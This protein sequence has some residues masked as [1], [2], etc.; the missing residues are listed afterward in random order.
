[1]SEMLQL[2]PRVGKHTIELSC[3]E[4]T[5]LNAILDLLI[6]S[7]K[8]FPPPSSL[9]IIDVFLHQ[10]RPTAEYRATL[11]LNEHRLRK[12]LKDLNVSAGGN[13]CTINREKQQKLLRNL[14]HQQPALF[15][16]LWTLVTHSYYKLLA[17]CS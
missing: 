10:L 11:M 8:D 2:S 7:D 5:Q 15:Q 14:E 9:Q 17:R 16:T 1:M 6:P 12:T 3:D 13:F 4:R